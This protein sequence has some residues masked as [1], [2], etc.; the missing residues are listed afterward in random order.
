MYSHLSDSKLGEHEVMHKISAGKSVV[1]VSYTVEN[2]T[3]HGERGSEICRGS[4]TRCEE[5]G[6]V[7]IIGRGRGGE[8]FAMDDC[9]VGVQVDLI[10]GRFVVCGRY[11]M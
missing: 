9:S 1:I 7:R 10:V 3:F 8:T 6:I 5:V 4:S 2:D 11:A